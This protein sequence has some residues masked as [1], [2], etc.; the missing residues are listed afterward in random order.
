MPHNEALIAR[1]KAETATRW[2]CTHYFES[3]P[4]QTILIAACAPHLLV[5]WWSAAEARAFVVG[6][7]PSP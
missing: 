5:S 2:G 7:A 6:A 3:D 4:M 1:Y